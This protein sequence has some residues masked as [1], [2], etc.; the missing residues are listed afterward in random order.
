MSRLVAV[1]VGVALL[2]AGCGGGPNAENVLKRTAASLGSIRS[3]TLGLK[4]LVTPAG[5]GS[6]F[7]FELRGP[8]RLG[9]SGL[10]VTRMAYTQIAGGRRAT[11]TLVSDGTGA[12]V[13]V[14][15]KEVPLSAGQEQTLRRA[16]Q[17]LQSA[18]GAGQ[19]AVGRW[20]KDAKASRD[21]NL[22]RV[23]GKLDVVEAVTT[24]LDVARLSGRSIGTLGTADRKRL[25]DAVRSSSFELT[26]GR[27]DHLLRSL[28][29]TVDIG[30]DVPE[31]L[32]AA[33]GN[34]VG[35]KVD[36]DVTVANPKR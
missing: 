30:L 18:G 36:F 33:L 20:V 28:E 16:A 25:A 21:G 8:F 24:L 31:E 15:G 10:P 9:T 14:G 5:S 29:L 34:L 7:G 17:Q 4:L 35:A 22:D 12:R 6:P 11:A 3:G 27:D 1:L 13:E 23:T 19:L 32:K 2:A 26:S